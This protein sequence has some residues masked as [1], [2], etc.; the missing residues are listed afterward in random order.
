MR[1][2]ADTGYGLGIA[3]SRQTNFFTVLIVAVVVHFFSP[4]FVIIVVVVPFKIP[5]DVSLLFFKA[6]L[7]MV[8]IFLIVAIIA[9]SNTHQQGRCNWSND[10]LVFG[11]YSL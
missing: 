4:I 11:C 6:S 8:E 9:N 5:F 2:S 10:L 1:L 3:C 7:C